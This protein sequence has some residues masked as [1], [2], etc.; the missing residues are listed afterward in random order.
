MELV[1]IVTYRTRQKGLRTVP[2]FFCT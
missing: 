2:Y 1:K